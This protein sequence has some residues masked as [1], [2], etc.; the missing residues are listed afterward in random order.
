ME[1]GDTAEIIERTSGIRQMI[2]GQLADNSGVNSS[3][4]QVIGGSAGIEVMT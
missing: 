1:T 2:R 3:S 4:A